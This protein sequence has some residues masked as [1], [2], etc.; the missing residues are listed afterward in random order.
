MKTEATTTAARP[1]RIS[2]G[3]KPAAGTRGGPPREPSSWLQTSHSLVPLVVAVPVLLGVLI[4]LG[5]ILSTRYPELGNTQAVADDAR[6]L[7]MGVTLWA[8]PGQQYTGSL[9][10]PLMLAL[11]APLYRLF[12]W[13]GWVL[14]VSTFSGV[15]LATLVGG[16]AASG[17]GRPTWE[18]IVGGF[19]LG[20]I[21][22]WIVTTDPRHAIYTGRVDELG[23]LFA[24][25][26]LCV[27]ALSVAH[28]WRRV[29]PAALLLTAAVWTKQPTAGAA[30]AAVAVA[31]WWAHTGAMTWR[32][33]GRFVAV[34][35]VVNV[36]LLSV[37]MFLT[38]G[39]VWFNLVELAARK[40]SNPAIVK[41]LSQIGHL[42]AIPVAAVSVAW[43]SG[44][45]AKRAHIQRGSFVALLATLLCAFLVIQFLPAFVALRQ[46]SNSLDEFIGMMWALGLLLALA[47]REARWSR[48]AMTAGIV[49]YT[50]IA[51]V[52]IVPPIRDGLT[53][54]NVVQP[55]AI[56]I[57]DLKSI[58]PAVVEYARSHLVYEPLLGTV[59]PSKTDEVWP[60]QVSLMDVLAAGEPGDYL[61]DALIERR[62]DAVTLFDRT[63]SSY[64]AAS[65][66]ASVEYLPALN[67]LI[68]LGYAKGDNGAPAPL[69]GRRPGAIVLTWARH[70]FSEANP[71]DCITSG[72]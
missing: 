20:G 8:K 38:H 29:W 33:W 21:A 35:G 34:L 23:W 63:Q 70:C 47:H 48:G 37:L 65:G 39:W 11:V 13:D 66:R 36:V 62:F 31:A 44:W 22:F 1:A 26:G 5:R 12:W 7:A 16:V 68:K 58:S 18:R 14:L 72:G 4:A 9:Y 56:S 32:A 2:S 28:R 60:Q 50:A 30:V 59:S 19:G 40:H 6:A 52:L 17:H 27:L 64:V 69:L 67:A 55:A 49:V 24:M 54:T 41:Y 25:S 43:A 71:K 46:E 10:A 45:R 51:I 42:F 53:R 61:V 57:P 3:S 15:G